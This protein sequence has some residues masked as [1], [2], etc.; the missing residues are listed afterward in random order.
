MGFGSSPGKAGLCGQFKQLMEWMQSS[1]MHGQFV[2]SSEK[3]G[4]GMSP[5][6]VF[7]LAPMS[8]GGVLLKSWQVKSDL[9]KLCW[10]G[11]NMVVACFNWMHGG[12]EQGVLPVVSAAQRRVHSRI[13]RTLEA[14]VMTDEP[15]LSKCGLEQFLRHTEFYTG[16][17]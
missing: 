8:R 16:E 1:A 10:A 15:I 11:G 9:D 4:V 17:V 2:S 6:H 13:E 5:S 12:Q 3:A 7:P 14:I